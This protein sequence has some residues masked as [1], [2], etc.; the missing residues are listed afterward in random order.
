M[1]SNAEGR[2]DRAHDVYSVASQW[3]VER[4]LSASWSQEDQ[5][6]L[7]K[8]LGQSTSHL[9]AYWRASHVW[10]R[11]DRL[12]AL[13]AP[14]ANTAKQTQ[15]SRGFKYFPIAA[16]IGIVAVVGFAFAHD[17]FQ[18]RYTTFVTA[19]GERKILKLSDGSL[20]E[21]NTGS[22]LRLADDRQR[23]EAILDKGEAYFDIKHN[24]A[25]PFVVIAHGRRLVDIGTKF[26]VRDEASSLRVSMIEGRAALSASESGTGASTELEAGDVAIAT[27]ATTKIVRTSRQTIADMAGWRRGQLVFRHVTLAAAV[28]EFNRYNDT[29]LSVEDANAGSK[30]IYGTFRTTDVKLFATVAQ[31]V[32]HLKINRKGGKIALSN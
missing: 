26:L 10:Q 27:R 29:K 4:R 8:W 1:T 28:A 7:D 13:K 2:H 5:T 20:I 19:V 17:F 9:V 12:A 14:A 32:L 3:V 11:A 22:V 30:K 6:R 21:L 25:Q 15:P 24:S 18:A 31:D 23:G 16:A